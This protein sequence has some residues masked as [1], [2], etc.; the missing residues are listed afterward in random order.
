MDLDRIDQR[1]VSTL[2]RDGRLSNQ[3]LAEVVGLSPSACLRRVRR[4]EEAGIIAGYR[5]VLDPRAVGRG[6]T[7]YVEITLES[8]RAAALDAFEAGVREC[9]GLRSC[10]LMAGQ[11]D[12]LL[13]L[14]VHDVEHY[15]QIHRGH[16]AGLPGITSIRS[17]FA[18]RSVADDEPLDLDGWGGTPSSRE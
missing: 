15:E 12:Y 10:H 11:A 14:Q 8:Q 17:T 2:Q 7:V 5:A 3:A 16:L 6:R 1:L 9:P 18:L 4:L 13:R